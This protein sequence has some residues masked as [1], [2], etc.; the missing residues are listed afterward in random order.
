VSRIVAFIVKNINTK[1]LFACL[2]GLVD[3]STVEIKKV[4]A[5]ASNMA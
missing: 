3:S 2:V 1:I 5:Q 4:K